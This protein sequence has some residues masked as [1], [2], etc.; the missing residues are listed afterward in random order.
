MEPGKPRLARSG[1]VL[2][3]ERRPAGTSV[4]AKAVCAR[5]PGETEQPA[6]QPRKLWEVAG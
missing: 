1:R 4:V 5:D 6:V 2:V 3:V